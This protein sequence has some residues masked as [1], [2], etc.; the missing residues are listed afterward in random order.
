[1]DKKRKVVN[2]NQER[3]F[4]IEAEAVVIVKKLICQGEKT[5]LSERLSSRMVECASELSNGSFIGWQVAVPQK[6]LLEMSVFGSGELQKKDLE[7]ISEHT[8]VPEGTVKEK[9]SIDFAAYPEIYEFSIP[10]AGRSGKEIGFHTAGERSENTGELPP[11]WPMVYSSQFGELVRAL[12]DSGAVFRAVLGSASFDEQELCRKHVTKTWGGGQISVEDYCGRPVKA[13]FLL[14]LPSAPT[15]R[16]RTILHESVPG[17]QLLY[18]GNIKDRKSKVVWNTPLTG[19]EILPDYA[20]RIMLLEP[21]VKDPVPGIEVAQKPAPEL[22]AS[23]PGLTAKQSVEIGRATS[24]AG[25][26]KKI[27]IGERDLCRHYQI[28]G[29]TGTGK[30]TLLA[31]MVLSAIREGFGLTF[32]DP[33]G[34]TIDTILRSVSPE[35]AGRIRV[36]RV[37]DAENPVPLNIWDS[38]DPQK[39]ERNISDLCELFSDI[40]DPKREGFVGPRYERWL[41]T[42]AKAS[43]AFL[44]RRASLESISV[45]SGN[46]QNMVKVSKAIKAKYPVLA[47]SILQE[48]GKDKSNDF[49]NILNWYLCKFERLT[50]VEQLRETLGAGTNAL[51]FEKQIDTDTVTLIDLAS[52][53]IG[54]QAARIVGTLMLMKLWNAAMK[55]KKRDMTHLVMIDEAALFQTNPMPRMLAESRKFGLSM[56]L[57]HQHTGQLTSEVRDALEANSA[58]L[59]AFRLSTADAR[60]ASIRFGDSELMPVLTGQS[61]FCAVTTISVNGRQTEPFTLKVPR[62]AKRKDAEK[63]AAAIEKRSIRTLVEPYRSVR[64]LT[65]QEIQ[66]KL[67]EAAAAADKP[68]LVPKKEPEKPAEPEWLETWRKKRELLQ[69]K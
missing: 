36:I 59:S 37:G 8:A 47:E 27:R 55:R 17:A 48:Y 4:P 41:S 5:A 19:A 49:V 18:I 60:N 40:F 52:P 28:I 16:L 32:F 69:K 50:S 22:L 1:M 21:F 64:A 13:R 54:T 11:Q 57:S 24:T 68:G 3:H 15:I 45:I 61:A 65:P 63:T 44:G 67:D 31:N 58:S 7:W 38:D 53:T 12:K 66:E 10:A 30:S 14:R 6:G 43:L 9:K 23:L 56:I 62:A 25:A 35:Q 34:T 42:F 26:A 51:D 33:H 46:Q 39:E 2:K 20:A 29:Q